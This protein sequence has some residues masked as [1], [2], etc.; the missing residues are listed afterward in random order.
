M[1]TEG[2]QT[3]IW[4]FYQARRQANF[5]KSL[6][7]LTGK[8]AELLSFNEVV[9]TLKITGFSLRKL[10][11]IPLDKI[12]GSVGRYADFTRRFLPKRNSD[13]VRWSRVKSLVTGLRGA[14]PIEVYQIDQVYFVIDG[15][16]RVSVA[17][18]L[19]VKCI[20]AYVTNIRTAIPLTTDTQ[21]DDLIINAEY[22]EFLERTRLDELRPGMDLTVTAVISSLSNFLPFS[23]TVLKTF[24]GFFYRPQPLFRYRQISEES[25][26][27]AHY[28]NQCIV[29]YLK[30]FF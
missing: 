23:L 7:F 16:H 26:V 12:V 10:Q 19:G 25:L 17:R 30:I 21:P 28:L 9:K 4:D 3:A 14:P 29:E 20:E 11:E 5:E 1:T 8:S 18:Q 2:Y 13:K 24:T 22:K 6:S 27:L 15:N